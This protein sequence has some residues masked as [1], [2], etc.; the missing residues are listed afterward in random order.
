[1]ARYF[2]D[3]SAL[4]KRY[5]RETGSDWIASLFQSDP[6]HTMLIAQI[7]PVEITSAIYR[8]YRLGQMSAGISA[9]VVVLFQRHLG[10]D[11]TVIRFTNAIVKLASS[12]TGKYPL[13]A[14]DAVQLGTALSTAQRSAGLPK[15]IF[16]TSD[17]RLRAAAEQEG[18]ITDD[19]NLH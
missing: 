3:T 14:Y 18:L 16:L 4:A 19:P 1:M 2:I 8:Q 11:F 13:H 6:R 5:M 15:L 17:A 9:R 10:Q 12:L 7:T